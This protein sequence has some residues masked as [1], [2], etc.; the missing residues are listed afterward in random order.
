MPVALWR[1]G[2][3]LSFLTLC[4]CLEEE[5]VIGI[6]GQSI[7]LPCFYPELSPFVNISI[8]WRRDDEVVLRSVWKEDGNVEICSINRVT[9]S[10]DAPVTGNFSLKV[11]TVDP[12]EGKIYYNLFIISPGNQSAPLC[13]VC[14]RTAASFSSPLLQREAAQGDKTVF[15]CH[16]SGGFPKPAVYWLINDTQTP[17]EGSVTTLTASLPDSRLY[18]VTSHLTA[19]IS[20]ESSVSCVIE[21]LF[22]KETLSSTSYGEKGVPVATRASE[23]M[24][25]FSTALC[26]VVGVM[27]LAGVVYQ[28]HLDRISKKKKKQYQH[29][30]RHPRFNIL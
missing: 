30:G 14:L 27:V 16:S 24:W 9:V 21:N 15:L 4:V 29:R 11:P 6:V 26:V 1:T 17:P 25:V 28:I 12:K 3:L 20:K 23:A 8:E 10:R 13:T 19:N 22:M 7:S 2:L 5:C 18:N